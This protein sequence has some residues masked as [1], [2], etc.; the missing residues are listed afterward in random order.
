MARQIFG[1]ATYDGTAPQASTSASS[2][3]D[4]TDGQATQ[5]GGTDD[6]GRARVA[7]ERRGLK[8]LGFIDL[9]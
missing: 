1:P 2:C 6:E 4:Q 5:Q 7:A 8:F 9:T 3:W